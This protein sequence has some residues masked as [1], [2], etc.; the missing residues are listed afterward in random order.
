MVQCHSYAIKCHSSAIQCH[1]PSNTLSQ[2]QHYSVIVP[3]IYFHYAIIT[4]SQFHQYIAIVSA[5]QCHSSINTCHSVS[6]TVSQYQQYSVI[7]QPIQC[8]S[9]ENTHHWGNDHS[10][11]TGLDST[12]QKNIFMGRSSR[13][14]TSQT[15]LWSPCTSCTA[16]TNQILPSS[17]SVEVNLLEENKIEQKR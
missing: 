3:A 12:N 16:A 1:S 2:C 10:G 6:I 14:Q 7:V 5:L 17:N 4:V 8:H 11:L 15:G 9:S 13:I